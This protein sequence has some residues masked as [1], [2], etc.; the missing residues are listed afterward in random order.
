MPHLFLFFFF[1]T[2]VL[3]AQN[4]AQK[5]CAADTLH[6]N[7]LFM[8]GEKLQ[9]ASKLDSAAICY[10]Q[11]AEIWK[12]ACPEI[13][14]EKRKRFWEGYLK[15]KKT[16]VFCFISNGMRILWLLFTCKVLCNLRFLG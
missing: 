14:G 8:L 13:K 6:A 5:N 1:F 11:A 7:E 16:E 9:K 4:Y 3:F 15:C 12:N 2:P 10:E